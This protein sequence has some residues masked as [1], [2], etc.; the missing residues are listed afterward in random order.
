M[1]QEDPIKDALIDSL[2]ED[3][4]RVIDTYAG[5]LNSVDVA[6]VLLSRVTL[7][8]T[9]HTEIGKGLVRYVWEKLDEIEQADPGNMI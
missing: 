4:D 1:S 6:G 8:M 3:I 9:M 7:L 5:G 2:I